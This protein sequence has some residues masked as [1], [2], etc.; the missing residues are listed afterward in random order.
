M[1]FLGQ[2]SLGMQWVKNVIYSRLS[3]LLLLYMSYMNLYLSMVVSSL[4]C[5]KSCFLYKSDCTAFGTA[6]EQIRTVFDDK[7]KDNFR[8][9]SIKTYVVGVYYSRL[10]ISFYGEI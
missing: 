6:V 10:A 1:E 7:N 8:Q 5:P 9:F 3:P 2:S 4:L